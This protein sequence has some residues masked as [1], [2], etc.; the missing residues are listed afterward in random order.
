MQKEVKVL[1]LHPLCCDVD[2]FLKYT[3][4]QKLTDSF[5][6][7]WETNNPD[8]LIVSEHINTNQKYRNKFKQLYNKHNI[9]IYFAGEAEY[10]DFNLY[11]YA[12]GF[13]TDLDL[14]DRYCSLPSPF[15]FFEGFISTNKN[16]II[17]S[18]DAQ[19]ELNNKN[20]FCNFLYSNFKAHPMRDKLFYEISKYKKVDSLGKHLNNVNE[21]GTGFVGHA[22]ECVAKKSRYK[23]SIA[24]ENATF[25]GYTSEKILTSLEAHTVPIYWGDPQV[26]KHINPKCFINCNEY[27]T[28]EEI[29]DIIKKVDE[30]DELWC[31]MISEPWQTLNQ[32]EFS[33]KLDEDYVTFFRNIFK[34]KYDE[35]VRIPK[36]TRPDIY[37]HYYFNAKSDT[38][39]KISLIFNK[40]KRKFCPENNFFCKN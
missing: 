25:P 5:K 12:V 18:E 27:T 30:D 15:T 4:L 1:M 19:Y 7:I 6:F 31:K 34:K 35:G 13:S 37:R 16:I 24:S 8:Y 17:S 20:G 39:S 33:K 21:P 3:G 29:I 28:I 10:P 9:K 2:S 26:I 36:G 22:N 11:D 40:I 14:N 23:F 38:V 32:A